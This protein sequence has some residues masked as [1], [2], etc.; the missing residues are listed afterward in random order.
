VLQIGAYK[1][2]AEAMASWRAYK[3]AHGAVANFEP[4]IR[5]VQL[6]GKGTWY[7]LRIGSFASIADANTLCA[8]LKSGGANC[9]PA[10]R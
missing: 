6:P 9:F 5:E 3:S 10:K 4:D 1:S 2:E 7:R 8:R